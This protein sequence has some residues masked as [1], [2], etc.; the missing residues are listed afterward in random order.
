VKTVYASPYTTQFGAYGRL[1]DPVT[2]VLFRGVD[3]SGFVFKFDR[4]NPKIGAAVASPTIIQQEMNP[5][6]TP[7]LLTGTRVYETIN[8]SVTGEQDLRAIITMPP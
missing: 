6:G 2:A 5:D 3:S 1:P 8:V 7:R 4:S